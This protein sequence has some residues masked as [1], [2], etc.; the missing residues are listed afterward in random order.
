MLPCFIS[1]PDMQLFYHSMIYFSSG[2]SVCCCPMWYSFAV[3]NKLDE[4]ECIVCCPGGLAILRA[5]FRQI[6]NIEVS[7]KSIYRV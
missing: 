1:L 2:M 5:K 3:A 7:L 6:H 4:N